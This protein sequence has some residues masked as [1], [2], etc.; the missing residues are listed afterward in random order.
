MR[1]FGIAEYDS[2]GNLFIALESANLKDLN[3]EANIYYTDKECYYNSDIFIPFEKNIKAAWQ[4][5]NCIF[6]EEDMFYSNG[7][8]YYNQTSKDDKYGTR[9]SEYKEGKLINQYFVE[10]VLR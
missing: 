5:Y 3:Q 1:R 7:A 10:G 4:P 8:Y 9:I 6:R 2:D